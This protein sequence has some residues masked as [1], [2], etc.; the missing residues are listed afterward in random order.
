MVAMSVAVSGTL[1]AQLARQPVGAEGDGDGSEREGGVQAD[2][3]PP[4]NP[5]DQRHAIRHEWRTAHDLHHRC[6][7][8]VPVDDEAVGVQRMRL[9]VA[10]H[11]HEQWIVDMERLVEKGHET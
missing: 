1:R 8:A 5:A 9:N 10:R 11:P 4:G 2:F 3:T 6:R 7:E